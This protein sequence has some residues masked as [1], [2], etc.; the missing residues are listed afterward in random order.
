MTT[1]NGS[2][3]ISSTRCRSSYGG[4]L[5]HK[6]LAKKFIRHGAGEKDENSRTPTPFTSCLRH[7]TGD[8]TEQFYIKLKKTYAPI[9]IIDGR[10]HAMDLVH[11]GGSSP[12]KDQPHQHNEKCTKR[13]PISTLPQ[14]SSRQGVA[15]YTPRS[16]SRLAKMSP[17]TLGEIVQALFATVLVAPETVCYLSNEFAGPNYGGMEGEKTTLP[18]STTSLTTPIFRAKNPMREAS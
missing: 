17:I 2:V 3:T 6:I 10:Q 7:S 5:V 8:D 14:R 18:S 9:R 12:R 1:C 15:G 4:M 11:D 16:I 13:G